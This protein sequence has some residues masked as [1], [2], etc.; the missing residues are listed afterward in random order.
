MWVHSQGSLE[1]FVLGVGSFRYRLLTF[2]CRYVCL[3][4]GRQVLDPGTSRGCWHVWGSLVHLEVLVYLEPPCI[5]DAV[6]MSG[7]PLVDPGSH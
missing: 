5:L 1:V 4:L 2:G 6:G 3:A 7:K